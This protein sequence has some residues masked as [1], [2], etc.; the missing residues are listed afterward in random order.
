M[1]MSCGGPDWLV[2]LRLS[3]YTRESEEGNEMSDMVGCTN[4]ENCW[5]GEVNSE[6]RRKYIEGHEQHGFQAPV[7]SRGMIADPQC[8]TAPVQQLDGEWLP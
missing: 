8:A 6:Q 3:L 5:A 7:C 2:L 1:G 4:G